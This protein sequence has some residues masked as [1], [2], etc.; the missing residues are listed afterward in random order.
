MEDLKH[1]ARYVGIPTR[2]TYGDDPKNGRLTVVVVMRICEGPLSGREVKYYNSKWERESNVHTF[3]KLRACGW[4]GEDPDTIVSD[5]E[6]ASKAGKRVSF[7][8][9]WV[10]VGNGFWSADNMQPDG[11]FVQPVTPP[12]QLSREMMK[13]HLAASKEDD[14][15]FQEQRAEQRG[16][17]GGN[18]YRDGLHGADPVEQR[19][20]QQKVLKP[21]DWC[22]FKDCDATI[23]S[24]MICGNG[25]EVIPF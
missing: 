21:G 15:R 17:P 10:E 5:I 19:I 13:Q 6:A 11:V 3:R 1:E 25:H 7:Q 23:E 4:K 24:N 18:S 22:P 8:A 9:R 2:P 12:S 14:R 20:E 16:N